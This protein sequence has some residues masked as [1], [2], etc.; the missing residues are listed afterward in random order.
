M[1]TKKKGKDSGESMDLLGG[2]GGGAVEA[3]PKIEGS[4]NRVSGQIDIYMVALE[5]IHHGA[6]TVGNTQVLRRENI[7]TPD[8]Q[9]H[10]VPFIS[11]NSLK[12]LLRAAM[13]QYALQVMDIPD[14]SLTKGVVDLLFS[15]G[16]LGAGG[17]TVNLERARHLAAMF[18]LLSVCGYSAGNS[19]NEARLSVD[20]I[21]M[22]C[23][24]NVWRMP[25][26]LKAD[27]SNE[28]FMSKRQARFIGTNFG[29]RHEAMRSAAVAP[30]LTDEENTRLT[31]AFAAGKGKE[32]G[33][34]QMIFD[35]EVIHPGARFWSTLFFRELNPMEKAAFVGG[36][37]QI[38][39]GRGP[40]GGFI[41]RIG[42]KGNSGHG[43]VEVFL[44]TSL[45]ESIR[46]M[47][48]TEVEGM[49]PLKGEGEDTSAQGNAE[50]AAYRNHLRSN[51]DEI[52]AALEASLK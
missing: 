52:V 45:R 5:P 25:D 16:H 28:T 40:N 2:A 38:Q 17:S 33:S 44:K 39:S 4:Y 1:A 9:F 50:M 36:L 48:F 19:M 41:W 14:G 31:E 6:G 37:Y 18:P 11:G 42:A 30:L 3:P 13:A 49:V 27:A 23:A 24:E 29:T 51:R 10:R 35:Y 15:G 26:Y 22:V 21:H 34:S 32:A 47:E 8:G 43:A 12:H 20:P 7:V 46:P